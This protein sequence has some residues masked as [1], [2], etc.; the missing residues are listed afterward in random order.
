MNP[1]LHTD[2]FVLTLNGYI[3]DPR[4][5]YYTL[6]EARGGLETIPKSI[7]GKVNIH[8]Y[9]STGI[10]QHGTDFDKPKKV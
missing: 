8:E 1:K 10:V 2:L 7:R 3:I 6:D 4:K 9:N 5:V